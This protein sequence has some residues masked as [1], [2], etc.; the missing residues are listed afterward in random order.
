MLGITAA[1]LVT[2][3]LTISLAITAFMANAEAERRRAQAEDLIGFMLGDLR[4]N[5]YEIGRLDV[6]MRVSDKVMDYFASLPDADDNDEMLHQR[7]KALRQIGET[8]MEQGES[9]L[10][11]ES[12]RESMAITR[13]LADRN[14]LNADWQ[15]ALANSHFYI[16]YIHWQRDELE[17]ARKEFEV[18]STIVYA[19]S[20]RDPNNPKW[21]MERGYVYTNLGRVLE[22]QGQLSQALTIYREAK[23]INDRLVELAPDNTDHRIEL[24]FAHNS[25][26]SVLKSLGQ[27]D[28]AEAHY[29]SDLQIKLAVLAEQPNH[30]LWKSYAAIGHVYKGRIL[31][32]RGQYVAAR[33]Q[34]A[35][36]L[37]I[38]ES[39]LVVDP[40]QT[41]WLER[42]ADYTRELGAILRRELALEKASGQIETSIGIFEDLLEIDDSMAS[43]QRG[44][45]MSRL[46]AAQLARM[47]RDHALA[48]EFATAAQSALTLLL[49]N[50]PSNQQTK[51]QHAISQLVA[52]DIYA[53]VGKHEAAMHAWNQAIETVQ[54][55]GA[56][57]GSLELRRLGRRWFIRFIDRPRR[58]PR[59]SATGRWL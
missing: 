14:P 13:Q 5:L 10:A 11:L 7:A 12:F 22:A 21:L 15:I 30:N 41:D 32:T 23:I 54:A 39:L 56:G 43:C 19:V 37:N 3:L 38:I 58:C 49:E 29:D 55:E 52:G 8:R 48:L 17:A 9:I 20:E 4:E 50:E 1:S 31:T 25:I 34:Y 6:F 16:G 36:A 40:G 47:H 35:S 27:L 45:A 18:T 26:G 53:D 2:A 42:K 28:E 33:E 57:A 24:G 46:E 59:L 51:S 44:L